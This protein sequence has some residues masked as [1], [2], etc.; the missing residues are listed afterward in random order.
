MVAVI[1]P[2]HPSHYFFKECDDLVA[3]TFCAPAVTSNLHTIALG[4]N[5]CSLRKTLALLV[6]TQS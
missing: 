4:D 6:M 1:A 2:G 5:V 3:E